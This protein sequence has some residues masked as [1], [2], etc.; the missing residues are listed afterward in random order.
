[1]TT[2][3]V[4]IFANRVDKYTRLYLDTTLDHAE[5]LDKEVQL[6]C[7][8][9][10]RISSSTLPLKTNVTKRSHRFF[11]DKQLRQLCKTSRDSWSVWRRA[12]RPEN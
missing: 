7:E 4:T 5:E 8:C 3:A 6:I 9:V 10:L 2:D 12:G 1:M 11:N